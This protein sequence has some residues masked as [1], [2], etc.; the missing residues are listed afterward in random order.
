MFKK[1]NSYLIEKLTV[2]ALFT[3]VILFILCARKSRLY[4]AVGKKRR[5]WFA[6][7]IIF[8]QV[9]TLHPP[10]YFSKQ[11]KLPE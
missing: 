5:H 6:I 1:N 9:S 2:I 8:S 11:Q 3:V 7:F 4:F 10:K